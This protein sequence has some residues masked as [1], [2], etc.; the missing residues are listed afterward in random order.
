MNFFGV[1]QTITSAFNLPFGNELKSLGDKV[2]DNKR[3][4]L[5]NLCFIIIDEFSMVK[6]DMLYQIDF[7][8]REIMQKNLPFGGVSVILEGDILQLPP[9]M[10]NFIFEKPRAIQS[11]TL[12][13]FSPLWERFEVIFLTHNHRQAEDKAYADLL[14]RV[15]CGEVSDNDLQLLSSR[16]R[17]IGS[18][19]I[20]ENALRVMVRNLEVNSYN[21]TKLSSLPGEEYVMEAYCCT[22]TQKKCSPKIDNTGAISGTSLQKTLCLKIGAIVMLTVN[23]STTDSLTNGTFGEV[24]GFEDKELSDGTKTITTVYVEFFKEKCVKEL[25]KNYV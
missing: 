9:V 2:R 14:N 23:L 15:R 16:K 18:T 5:Q 1:K 6:S 10:A 19:D 25:R 11:E 22:P 7:R 3:T 24:L 8:L 12:Y 21:A 4:V 13:T 20:P 17:A